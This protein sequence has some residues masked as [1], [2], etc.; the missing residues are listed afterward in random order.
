MDTAARPLLEIRDLSLTIDTIE[1]RSSVLDR[2]S[3]AIARGD[4]LGLVGESGCGKSTLVRAILR[5]LPNGARIESGSIHLGDT[6]LLWLAES[7]LAREIRGRRIAFI[8]QDPALSLNPIF[9]VGTQLVDIVLAHDRAGGRRAAQSR[10]LEL[11]ALVGLPDPQ[12]V[13]ARHPHQLSGGQRQRVLIAAALLSEPELIVADE[14]T[15][16]LDVTT[17]RQVLALLADVTRRLGLS[18]LFVTHDFG[19]VAQFC[20]RVAVMYA[21]QI[22]EIGATRALLDA[23]AHPYTAALLAC[24]PDRAETRGGIPGQVPSLLAPPSGCRF[25]T[26]CA[27]ATDACARRPAGLVVGAADDRRVACVL[28]DALR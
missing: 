8:P 16:A 9:T 14:P 18:V 11:F 23:P 25:R 13:L 10:I 6:E 24:H 15:T 1:G 2:V 19:V 3:L 21:G 26:R 20:T 27:H 28:H 12:R 5:L 17:Q 7:R 22:V 4:V